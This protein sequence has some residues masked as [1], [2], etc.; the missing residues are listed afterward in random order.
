MAGG[1][2]PGEIIAVWDFAFAVKSVRTCKSVR[3]EI[4]DEYRL[5]HF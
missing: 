5:Y 3:Q 1:K 4:R 2:F